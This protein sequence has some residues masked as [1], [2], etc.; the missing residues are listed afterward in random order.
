MVFIQLS[1][2]MPK[3]AT[4]K[5]EPGDIGA[6]IRLVDFGSATFVGENQVHIKY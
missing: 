6:L 2:A 5:L 1:T 3:T 4:T